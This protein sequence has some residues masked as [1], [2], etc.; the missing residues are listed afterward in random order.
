MADN[1]EYVAIEMHLDTTKDIKEI[2]VST[3]D[4]LMVCMAS[5]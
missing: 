1:A 3:P 2:S 5:K 4:G